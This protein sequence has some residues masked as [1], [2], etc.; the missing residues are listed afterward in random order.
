MQRGNIASGIAPRTDC[1]HN[2]IAMSLMVDSFLLVTT[3]LND[4]DTVMLLQT[5]A[6]VDE[7]M[8]KCVMCRTSARSF[9]NCRSSKHFSPPQ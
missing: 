3:T 1:S 8:G 5:T 2:L 6:P 4:I 9:G 7:V